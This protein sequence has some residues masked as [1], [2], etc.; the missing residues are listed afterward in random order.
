[1]RKAALAQGFGNEAAE[2]FRRPR[3]HAGRD[4]LGEKLKQKVGHCGVSLW[5]FARRR[6]VRQQLALYSRSLPKRKFL[7]RENRHGFN[8]FRRG[9]TT[10]PDRRL[11][12]LIGGGAEPQGRRCRPQGT[13]KEVCHG[14][15]KNFDGVGY[16][17]ARAYRNCFGWSHERGELAGCIAADCRSNKPTIITGIIIG[18]MAGTITDIIT[19]AGATTGMVGTRLRRPRALPLAWLRFR[20]HWQRAA[21]PIITDMGIPTITTKSCSPNYCPARTRPAERRPGHMHAP[22]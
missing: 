5:R 3:L 21:G 20:S 12:N 18:T 6:G 13:S 8:G 15:E 17:L 4:F 22:P 9:G 10:E 16:R 19:T 1:M 2:I 11:L 14:F 7:L